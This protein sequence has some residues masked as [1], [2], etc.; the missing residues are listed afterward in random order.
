MKDIVNK[1]NEGLL[2][3]YRKESLATFRMTLCLQIKYN[4][5][6][7]HQIWTNLES[8]TKYAILYMIASRIRSEEER[9]KCSREYRNTETHWQ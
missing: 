8:S 7:T 6:K 5:F 3:I 9:S 1:W 2:K 4:S